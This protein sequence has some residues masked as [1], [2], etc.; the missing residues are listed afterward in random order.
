MDFAGQ[1]EN[2]W[3]ISAL[4]T[5]GLR[6]E[7][8]ALRKSLAEQ[9]LQR[10][11]HD[12]DEGAA[13]CV[14]AYALLEGEA[15]WKEVEALLAAAEPHMADRD[16]LAAPPIAVR[17]AVSLRYICGLLSLQGGHRDQGRA[18][19]ETCAMLPFM[20]YSPLLATKTVAAAVRLAKLA[21]A[22]HDEPAAERQL[23]KGLELSQLAVCQDWKLSL[24]DLSRQP[25]AALH[26]L[27]EVMELAAQCAAGLSMLRTGQPGPVFLEQFCAGKTSEIRRLT[28]ENARLLAE[29]DRA[30][31]ALT[32]HQE[33][34]K[35]WYEASHFWE[36][37]F[38]T[39]CEAS[40]FWQQQA[41]QHK[42]RLD[43]P[44]HA[45]GPQKGPFG[46]L[47]RSV[48]KRVWRLKQKL[49]GAG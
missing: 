10:R 41:E 22:D 32:W 3:L 44:H 16:W 24:G 5:R 26:E 28:D 45:A 9:T 11:R 49:G 4:L 48:S 29:L 33:Q 12:A 18:H 20:H 2:P 19:L 13:L 1:Y 15:D 7:R 47:R 36:E 37:Q 43:G 8:T 6:T 40:H 31:T 38:K 14:A 23:V 46:K 27:A 30:S 39:W 21:L 42:S 34:L 35:T 17:W 25:L